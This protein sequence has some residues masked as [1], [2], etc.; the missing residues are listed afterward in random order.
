MFQNDGIIC[1][2]SNWAVDDFLEQN[3]IDVSIPSRKDHSYTSGLSLRNP[4]RMFRILTNKIND[5]D[6]DA[7][8]ETPELSIEG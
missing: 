1:R 2:R 8:A 5:F 6:E 7:D 3:F 4:K